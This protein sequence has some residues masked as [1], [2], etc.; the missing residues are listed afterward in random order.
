MYATENMLMHTNGYIIIVESV[1]KSPLHGP[2]FLGL[3][4]YVGSYF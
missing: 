1:Y 4:R 3:N 2:Q